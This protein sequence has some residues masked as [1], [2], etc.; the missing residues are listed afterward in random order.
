MSLPC[1]QGPQTA[2]E[3][4]FHQVFGRDLQDAREACK[5]WRLFGEQRDLDRAWE[6]YYS[7]G[8]SS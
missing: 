3:T 8:V 2:R 7:V 4:S 5:R 6:I 1:C